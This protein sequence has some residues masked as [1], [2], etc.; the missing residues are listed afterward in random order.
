MPPIL[1]L[2]QSLNLQGLVEGIETAKLADDFAC[3]RMPALRQGWLFGH[4]IP[5]R[6]FHT[7]VEASENAVQSAAA[8]A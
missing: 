7:K 8:P 5:A 4:P 3:L 6:D 2:A 1:A